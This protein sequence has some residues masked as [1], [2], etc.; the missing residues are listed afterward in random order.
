L[1]TAA[2]E[3]LQRLQ[4]SKLEKSIVTSSAHTTP[5]CVHASLTCCHLNAFGSVSVS[6]SLKQRQK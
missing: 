4:E 2:E 5:G 6:F 3:A 1:N